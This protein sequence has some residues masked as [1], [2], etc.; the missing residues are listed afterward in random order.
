MLAAHP[1]QGTRLGDIDG[2]GL[3]GGGA[4]GGAD[5][6]LRLVHAL[7]EP[8]A[9][10]VDLSAHPGALLRSQLAHALE[11]RGQLALF[12]K[13]PHAQV[14]QGGGA[15]QLLELLPDPPFDVA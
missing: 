15:I 10:L 12:A 7:G 13:H 1:G 4:L 11:Q 8:L 5:A 9:H 3:E 14:F 6:G 2:L